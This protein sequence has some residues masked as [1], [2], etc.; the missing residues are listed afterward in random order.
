MA[1]YDSN[2]DYLF[3][4]LGDP[5]RRAILSRLA[6]G[7]ATVSELAEPHQMALPSF[8]AHLQKLEEAGLVTSTKLGRTR[9][10]NL[11]PDGLVPAQDWM[12]EQRALW[13][14]RLDTLDDYVINLM[15]ERNNGTG[16]KD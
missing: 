8:L 6:R 14:G 4:A 16:S 9:F 7:Q 15:K 12:S 10:C 3:T 5:T 13:A 11:S 1:K 2:L